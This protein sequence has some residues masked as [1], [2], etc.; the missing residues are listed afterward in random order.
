MREVI[1]EKIARPLGLKW[2]SYGVPEEKVDQVAKNALT[3][4][5]IIPPIKQLLQRA[6]GLSMKE[7]VDLSNDPRF[8]TG[9]IPSANICST[10]DEI[11][12]F[13]Q[14]M[15]QGGE[16]N[17]ESV[18]APRTI[19]HAVAEQSYWEFDLTLGFPIRYSLGFMLGNPR[20]G[21]LGSDNPF[22]FGHVG[23]SNVFTWADPERGISVALLTSGKPIMSPHV[24]PLFALQSEIGKVFSRE[25]A[26]PASDALRHHA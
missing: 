18:F 15:L 22:A 1:E 17:G 11:S 9:I 3:G 10:A 19:R 13:Y 16:W 8:L 26:E 4:Y 12:S 21:P 23:L 7:V 2:L 25:L 14:C 24:V 6:L 5:P 20:A